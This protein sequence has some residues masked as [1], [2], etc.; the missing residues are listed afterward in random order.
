MWFFYDMI[1]WK[2]HVTIQQTHLYLIGWKFSDKDTII[3]WMKLSCDFSMIWLGENV[4]WLFNKLTCFWLAENIVTNSLLFD[5]MK[6]I[7]VMWLYSRSW[8]KSWQ[9]EQIEYGRLK[10]RIK[11]K[12]VATIHTGTVKQY[13]IHCKSTI[14]CLFTLSGFSHLH[15]AFIRFTFT[16]FTFIRF[17]FLHL[18]IYTLEY[19]HLHYIY[20][21]LHYIHSHF[22][23][24]ILSTLW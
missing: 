23:L 2:C 21:H 8:V 7:Y 22:L 13:C 9:E 16:L 6:I 3:D 4:M 18:F 5:W 20:I 14:F 17:T 10:E 24:F 11:G 12:T 19:N 15:S 1:G